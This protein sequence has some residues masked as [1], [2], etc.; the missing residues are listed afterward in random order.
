M[1]KNRQS[2]IAALAGTATVAARGL[3]IFGSQKAENIP[4]V[5]KMRQHA[6]WLDE[7]G[8]KMIP[9]NS[10]PPNVSRTAYELVDAKRYGLQK[11]LKA[12]PLYAAGLAAPFLSAVLTASPERTG[13]PPKLVEKS[14]KIGHDYVAPALATYGG[15]ASVSQFGTFINGLKHLRAAGMPTGKLLTEAS[16]LGLLSAAPIIGILGAAYALRKGY[17]EDKK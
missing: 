16:R 8:R 6:V 15:L 11:L 17:K 14:R 10:F 2:E 4:F 12:R 1:A 7:S 5:D 3:P 9:N 13:L